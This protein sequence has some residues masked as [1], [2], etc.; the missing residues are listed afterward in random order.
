LARL[1][2]VAWISSTLP[3]ALGQILVPLRGNGT[4]ALHSSARPCVLTQSLPR[5]QFCRTILLVLA[6]DLLDNL[7]CPACRQSLEYRQ[8][9]ESLKCMKCHRV[10]AVKDDI[11]IML[12]DD[13]TIE[14]D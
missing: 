13:A 11:P 3:Q 12:I 8:N 2:F 1:F 5:R 10:Y 4:D 7:V 14:N 9:P 6:Q